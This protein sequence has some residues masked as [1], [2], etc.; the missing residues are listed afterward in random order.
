MFGI[1]RECTSFLQK[2][3]YSRYRFRNMPKQA[4]CFV[5]TWEDFNKTG[6][7]GIYAGFNI[8]M[9]SHDKYFPT[10]GILRPMPNAFGDTRR[11]G[12]V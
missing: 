1:N 12:G 8:V 2:L 3:D 7:S 5:L 4:Q 6:V 9:I 11:T 10:I